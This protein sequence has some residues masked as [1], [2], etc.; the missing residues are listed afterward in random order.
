[1]KKLLAFGLMAAITV[2]PVAAQEAATAGITYD[3][4]TAA[5]RFSQLVLPAETT[6]FEVTGKVRFVQAAPSERYVPMTRIAISSRTTT[7][8]PSPDGWAGLAYTVVSPRKEREGGPMLAFSERPTGGRDNLQPIGRPSADEIA[9]TL[10]FD[11]AEVTATVEGKQRKM[12]LAVSRPVV[13]I[14]CSTAEFL[15][16]DLVIRPRD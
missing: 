11:G 15:Y 6:S 10:A 8:G 12:P 3:C 13:M 4:D 2:S 5:D 1:M 9:F 7:S 14:D 16:T